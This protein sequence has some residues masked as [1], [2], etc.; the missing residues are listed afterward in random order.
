MKEVVLRFLN[1]CWIENRVPEGWGKSIIIP[2]YKGTGDMGECKNYKEISLIDH[3][4]KTYERIL[5]K[6]LRTII[7]P[8]LDDQHGFRSNRSTTDLMFALRMMIEKMWEF[9]RK[10][11]IAFIDLRNAFDSM[12]RE[13]LWRVL[14]R[15]YAVRGNLK[16]AMESMY[17]NDESRSEPDTRTK[18]GLK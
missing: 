10:V 17:K 13:R 2:L 1:K 11:Y 18:N 14:E 8:Q 3:L 7:E 6:R 12:P 9:N 16:K 15:E 4:A 5:E